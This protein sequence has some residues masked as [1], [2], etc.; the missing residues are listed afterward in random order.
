MSLRE[1]LLTREIEDLKSKLMTKTDGLNEA[2]ERNSEVH[3]CTCMTELCMNNTNKLL[4]SYLLKR[5]IKRK[6]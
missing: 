6:Y 3:V 4:C 5:K 2:I 1:S